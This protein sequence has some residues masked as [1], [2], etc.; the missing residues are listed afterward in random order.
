MKQ[1]FR[2][3]SGR[4]NTAARSSGA[5]HP[6][7]QKRCSLPRISPAKNGIARVQP[8]ALAMGRRGHR[9]LFQRGVYH[10]KRCRVQR[11]LLRIPED[12]SEGSHELSFVLGDAGSTG[13][14]QLILRADIQIVSQERRQRMFQ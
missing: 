1:P 14:K 12:A 10:R 7:Q 2:W 8:G 11:Y 13:A 3:N 6:I 5:R 9:R 4:W